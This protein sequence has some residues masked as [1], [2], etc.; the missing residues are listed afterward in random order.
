[1][2]SQLNA[3]IGYSLI[4]Y[5]NS[6]SIFLPKVTSCHIIEFLHVCTRALLSRQSRRFHP[7]LR[8]SEGWLFV[9][10]KSI[11]K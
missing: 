10:H 6:V 9:G 1:M 2:I 11:S 4:A 8:G 5:T 3:T 7:T